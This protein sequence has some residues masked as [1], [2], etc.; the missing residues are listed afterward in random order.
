MES[1]RSGSRWLAP[2]AL[3]AV[4]VV[5]LAIVLSG[6]GPGSSSEPAAGEPAAKVERKG[7]KVYV[8]KPGDT[9]SGIAMKTDISVET[10]QALNPDVDVQALQPGT[11]L[12]LRQ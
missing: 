7:P 12:R 6:G 1:S 10:L 3:M 8:V 9:L 4:A 5:A 2:L 11:R